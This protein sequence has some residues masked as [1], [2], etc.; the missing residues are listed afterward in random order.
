[1][2]AAA[3]G[4][5]R[6]IPFAQHPNNISEVMAIAQSIQQMVRKAPPEFWSLSLN[7][8]LTE[9]YIQWKG[10]MLERSVYPVFSALEDHEK[11]KTFLCPLTL[12]FITYPVRDAKGIFFEKKDIER[13]LDNCKEEHIE[14][15][16]THPFRM[17]ILTKSNL[18]PA[19]EYY[20]AL[21]DKLKE[22]LAEE[23]IGDEGQG[24]LEPS[25]NAQNAILDR[26]MNPTQLMEQY[27]K[28]TPPE[29]WSISSLMKILEGAR[30]TLAQKLQG[31]LE[32]QKNVASMII[33]PSER[34]Y[35]LHD[36][37]LLYIELKDIGN[38]KAMLS[39]AV[40][41]ATSI[42]DKVKKCHALKVLAGTYS[43][44][45]ENELAVNLLMEASNTDD[46]AASQDINKE[47]VRLFIKLG[48]LD[49]AEKIVQKISRP[50]YRC[51]ALLK[52]SAAYIAVKND[53]F[54]RTLEEAEMLAR[55]LGSSISNGGE[56]HLWN[57]IICTYLMLNDLNGA[58]EIAKEFYEDKVLYQIIKC[59]I[60]VKKLDLAAWLIYQLPEVDS[61]IL[62]KL[63]EAYTELG[64]LVNTQKILK[65][66]EEMAEQTQG[67]HKS[68]ILERIVTGYIKINQ[69]DEAKR[70]ANQIE[71]EEPK[72]SSF[73]KISLA[74]LELESADVIH[75]N[76]A[77]KNARGLF[78][79]KKVAA[80]KKAALAYIRLNRM[81]DAQNIL[82]ELEEDAEKLTIEEIPPNL[83]QYFKVQKLKTDLSK[84][85]VSLH[86]A[87]KN[88]DRAIEVADSIPDVK[89]K[90]IALKEII[91][92]MLISILKID[93]SLRANNVF[94]EER[95]LV[96]LNALREN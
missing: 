16:R 92:S 81:D 66:L 46:W 87:F 33:E 85:I 67:L 72:R 30:D 68:S 47:I 55:G 7:E 39:S 20:S 71:S 74:Y 44:I 8:E 5:N 94:E 14:D 49:E 45:E 10:K 59:C 64:D 86:L 96:T 42:S 91:D 9:H 48:K 51:Q 15:F 89:I 28:E 12:G 32:E 6:H 84:E 21:M 26:A 4:N 50:L 95:R 53:F 25:I 75:I 23:L 41:A 77:G 1:M 3:V 17:G 61:F 57:E 90:S 63:A 37:A 11:I 70:I 34:Y 35:F 40:E 19:P 2:A 36:I 62:E 22:V 31:T 43:K 93:E 88:F 18:R 52:I 58:K 79:Y 73:Q 83:R 54:K 78:F 27:I 38:A 76:E 65:K 80:L 29:G 56:L 60:K 82:R 24:N 13:Y 69:L